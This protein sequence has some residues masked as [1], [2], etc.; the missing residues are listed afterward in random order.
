MSD[1]NKLAETLVNLKIVEVND[2]AK[3]LK[4]KY[5]LDPSAN[6]AIPS[7]PKAEILDKS[8]E[9]TSF[10][11]ILK[12]AGSAKL[13]VVK[14]IK[15]LIGLGLKE[16][17]DLVDNVPKHLK[18]GLSKEEAESLKKQLEE[19]GAEVELK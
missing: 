2:L 12:G 8:K 4:E 7:L 16:S 9:K 11:L 6:L 18:K 3:I 15:D 1:I 13:T 14:R 10:D 17:K 5:G 19:V